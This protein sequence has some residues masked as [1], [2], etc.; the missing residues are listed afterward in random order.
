M[1]E[2]K[3]VKRILAALVRACAELAEEVGVEGSGWSELP[4][5]LD[6]RPV[7]G[8]VIGDRAL[9]TAARDDYALAA[10]AGAGRLASAAI[11]SGVGSINWAAVPPGKS[12]I[13]IPVRLRSG[14]LSASSGLD[15]DGGATL[16]LLDGQQQP[17]TESTVWDHDWSTTSVAV[18]ADVEESPQTH[19]R[20]RRFARA[21]LDRPAGDAFLAE[22]LAAES[23][24]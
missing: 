12:A 10:G 24:Y 9:A 13:G 3:P 21:R 1:R 23:N 7:P 22:I 4:S 19:E 17:V 14:S 20:I 6:G 8:L 2:G 16:R 18:G 11:A 15:A 5:A